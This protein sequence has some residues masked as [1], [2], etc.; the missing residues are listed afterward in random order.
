MAGELHSGCASRRHG[1]RMPVCSS[2]RLW[3][4]TC[5][6]ISS[7]RN[8]VC[9]G[10]R[11]R[12]P[13]W[14]LSD[15]SVR[16]R[17]AKNLITER[18]RPRQFIGTLVSFGPGCRCRPQPVVRG[19]ALVAVKRSSKSC[20]DA[21][22]FS[23][24]DSALCPKFHLPR[25]DVDSSNAAFFM[26]FTIDLADARTG[27]VVGRI[28]PRPHSRTYIFCT[29]WTALHRCLNGHNLPSDKSCVTPANRV[30]AR[31]SWADSMRRDG[32]W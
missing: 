1:P 6:M 26:Q 32:A 17:A 29:V 21:V 20:L 2:K 12:R 14:N 5:A 15:R 25:N 24:T 7:C 19:F 16:S 28:G 4:A 13:D 22:T 10:D 3:F 8:T 11:A 9:S 23:N 30:E 18:K 27:N 31:R